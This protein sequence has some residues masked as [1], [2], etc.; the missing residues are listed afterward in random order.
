M[1]GAFTYIS[2]D[3]V[4]VNEDLPV[5]NDNSKYRHLFFSS[6]VTYATGDNGSPRSASSIREAFANTVRTRKGEQK[7]STSDLPTQARTHFAFS[8]EIPRPSRQGE[9]MPPTCSSVSLG[10]T[11]TRGRTC[12]ERAEVEYKIIAIWEGSDPND[13]TQ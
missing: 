6:T 10:V 11:G 5:G 3:L 8:Y 7:S 1:E 2:P 12:V 4:E 9:E 13:R